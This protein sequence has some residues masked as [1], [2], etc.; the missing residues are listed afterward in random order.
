MD[1]AFQVSM[2]YWY[3]QHLTL[4]SPLDISTTG[5]HF[6]FGSASSL[7]L[8]LFL[9]S[10]PVASLTPTDLGS[11]SFSVLSLC[12]FILFMGFSRKEFRSSLPFSP[13]VDH[14]LSELSTMTHLSW[15]TLHVMA[16]GFIKLHKAMIRVIIL[17][18]FL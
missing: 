15:V 17:V 14:S 12:L 9:C 18:S 11:S 1:L 6:L 16:H 8:E 2:Q 4:L 5:S 10:P 7:L 13:P 3:L